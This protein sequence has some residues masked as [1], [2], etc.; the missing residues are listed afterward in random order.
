MK[1]YHSS[2]D[3]KASLPLD[4]AATLALQALAYIFAD[5]QL[6][7]RFLS[8]TGLRVETLRTRADQPDM[9]AAVLGFLVSHEPDLIACAAQLGVAPALLVH[10]E[11]VLV[12]S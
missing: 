5:D 9:L 6:S 10:A 11:D 3:A 8:L 12:R 2:R 1:V 4:S 7:E